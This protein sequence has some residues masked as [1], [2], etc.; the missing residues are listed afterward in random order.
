MRHY[1]SNHFKRRKI[2][3]LIENQSIYTVS[4]A[5]LS[6]FET[7]EKTKNIQLSFPFPVIVSMLSGKKIMGVGEIKKFDFL[8]DEIVLTPQNKKLLIDFPL[9]SHENP[10]RCITLGFDHSYIA[11]KLTQLIENNSPIDENDFEEF[12]FQFLHIKNK[13]EIQF[14][15]KRMIFTFSSSSKFKENILDL[16][17]Q[18]LLLRIIQERKQRIL[19][20]PS[21]KPKFSKHESLKEVLFYIQNHLTEKNISIEK[22]AELAYLSPSHFHKIFKKYLGVSPIEYIN[23]KR[24]DFAKKL[25]SEKKTYDL[26]TIGYLSGFNSISYFNRIFKKYTSL[27][28]GQYRNKIKNL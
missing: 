26:K 9:A 4:N 5:E 21:H 2:N 12:D 8:P 14:L 1:L 16:M 23:K 27:T 7:F 15:I 3:D 19:I 6:I 10:T 18:E 22:L 25:L 20:D 28:P 13:P 11:K 17:I 24:I